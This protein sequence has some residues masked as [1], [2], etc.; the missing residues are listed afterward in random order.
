MPLARPCLP[1]GPTPS[2]PFLADGGA[3]GALLR[4]TDWS[5]H[6]WG[7][8]Q[9]WP[10]A[11][12]TM[13]SVV[14]RAHQPMFVSWGPDHHTIYNDKYAE[15]SGDRHP[16]A[17]GAPM[18]DTWQEI[19]ERVA[20]FVERVYAGEALHMEDLQVDL[21]R[22]GRMEQA[23]FSFSY[24]PVLDEAGIIR[25]IFCACTEITGQVML[26]RNLDHERL[27]LRSMFEQSPSFI[28]M[29]SGPGHVLE[30]ANA[31]CNALI[32]NRDVTGKPMAEALP[33]LAAQGFI[34]MLDR[35]YATGS[36]LR[37]DDA[38]LFLQR[39]PDAAREERFLDFV[40]QPIL[41]TAGEVTGIF[42]N[43]IDVTDR[44]LASHALRKSEQFV[45]SVLEASDD[46]VKV[47]D[48]DGRIVFMNHG[49]RQIMEVPYDEPVEGRLWPLLWQNAERADAIRALEKAISGAPATFHGYANTHAGTRK[50]W[51]VR[52][53][54]MLDAAG[55]TESILAVSRDISYLRRIEE[56]RETLMNELSHRLKNA[57]SM[58]QSMIGQTLRQSTS[59]QQAREILTGRVR[60]LAAAQDIL[61]R[62]IV[63][64]MPIEEV[65]EAAVLPHRTGEGVFDISG[66]PAAITG[67][68]GL[69]LSLA[70]H[71]LCTNATKYGA[72]S[73]GGG[74][75]RIRW[76]VQ[77]GG[78]FT[79]EWQESG[80][81]PVTPPER[82]GFGSVLIEKVVATY[83]DGSASLDFDEAGVVFR[84]TGNI[85]AS[86]RA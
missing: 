4:A 81:P 66:P 5:Q 37:I 54:P 59:V 12:Q 40:Y 83:F 23:H 63:S 74:S 52:L 51:D 79:F 72:M 42:A 45:R 20:G 8:P 10:A 33:E 75:V 70:L 2:P 6:P 27:R 24:T 1:L 28:A 61:T 18:L 84:L 55:K 56:E 7:Q 30:F 25:G 21:R 73:R 78:M 50:Y 35:V 80:G 47:L 71:E 62:S 38:K 44:T 26:Q 29:L 58:V 3:T 14:M 76:N 36:A 17:L 82:S 15:I 49:G 77:P 19:R 39:V 46:C 64:E 32:G 53:T 22:N 69:G 67:R 31:A 57:F 41:D 86:D 13:T 34:D 65:V 68:Q 16:A 85:P 43:G 60:A 11:L 48:M 9:G